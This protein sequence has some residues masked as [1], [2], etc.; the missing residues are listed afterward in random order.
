MRRKQRDRQILTKTKG[1]EGQRDCKTW[2]RKNREEK[3][4]GDGEM[5]R[6]Q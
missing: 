4:Q 2:R 6:K 3:R 1:G 5:R